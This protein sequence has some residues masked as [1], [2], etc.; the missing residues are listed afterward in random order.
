MRL[1]VLLPPS[2]PANSKVRRIP[3][4]VLEALFEESMLVGGIRTGMMYKDDAE[5]I[6]WCAYG[7]LHK[8]GIIPGRAKDLYHYNGDKTIGF[9]FD[10][11]DEAVLL[12][13]VQIGDYNGLL[14]V[15]QYE[16]WIVA[17]HEVLEG[18]GTTYHRSMQLSN[19]EEDI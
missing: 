18:R 11:S 13:G 16:E 5:T 3:I 10:D 4:E 6:P 7:L 17:L 2:I 1:D 14:S 15:C 8:A 9:T 19:L 12:V